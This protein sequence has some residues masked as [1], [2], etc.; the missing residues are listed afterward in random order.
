MA[1]GFK[2]ADEAAIDVFVVHTVDTIVCHL[3]SFQ[4]CAEPAWEEHG[5]DIDLD[6]PVLVGPHALLLDLL[7]CCDE[8]GGR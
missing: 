2:A 4:V 3:I 5:I 1:H 6:D 7:P 8:H